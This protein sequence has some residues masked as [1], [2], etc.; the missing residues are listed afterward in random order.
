MAK[1]SP[2]KNVLFVGPYPP[3]TDG[4]SFAFKTIFDNYN[5]PKYLINQNLGQKRFKW[6]S[7]IL[8][9]IMYCKFFFKKDI[10][11]IY[12]AGSRSFLGSLK[13]IILIRL[14]SLKNIKFIFHLHAANFDKFIENINPLFKNY[15]VNTYRKIDVFIILLD[16]MQVEYKQFSKKSKIYSVANFYDEIFENFEFVKNTNE[17]KINIVYFSNL[18][19]SKGILHL[20]EAFEILNRNNKNITLMIAGSYIGDEYM[21]KEEVKT[22]VETFFRSNKNIT[23]FGL[24][25]GKKKKE[26]LINADIFVLPTFYS[27]E[28]FPISI[29]E[30]M[31]CGCCIITTDHNYLKYIV[32][33]ENGICIKPKSVESIVIGIEFFLKNIDLLRKIQFHNMAYSKANYSQLK[34]VNNLTKIIQENL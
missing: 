19:Y 28:A 6:L 9:L 3:P 29:V 18:V 2:K 13:D 33:E 16:E 11:L 30:A 26:L 12:F 27:V 4:Q 22:K 7:A 24:L 8:I 25:S 5:F 20:L 31:S 23:Y 32:S 17:E 1:N 21:S 15:Y 14:F 34:Y 10:S